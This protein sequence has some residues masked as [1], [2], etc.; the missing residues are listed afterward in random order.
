[1]SLLLL[2]LL[3]LHLLLLLLLL[4]LMRAKC[5]QCERTS[6]YSPLSASTP[7]PQWNRYWRRALQ[8]LRLLPALVFAQIF[9]Y[10]WFFCSCVQNS[11]ACSRRFCWPGQA[12]SARTQLLRG[13]WL[14]FLLLFGFLLLLFLG[15]FLG[16][17]GVNW[18]KCVSVQ[19]QTFRLLLQQRYF[20]V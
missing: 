18:F 15:G 12:D 2:S 14:S 11:F 19:A 5:F 6:P 9:Y 7:G 16:P 8:R 3:L 20:I 13:S 4:I 10:F 17:T 1:M